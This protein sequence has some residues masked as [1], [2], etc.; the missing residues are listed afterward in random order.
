MA[1]QR[2][3]QG[4]PPPPAVQ[5]VVLRYA[6]RGPLRY[7][8][9]RDLAR[10]F[11]R[12]LRRARVPMAYSAGFHPHPKLSYL[13]AA[14]TGAASEAEYLEVRLARRVE[15][16]ELAAGLTAVLPRD[17][18]I[19]GAVDTTGSTAGGSAAGLDFGAL[20]QASMW[21]LEWD[22]APAPGGVDPAHLERALDTLM[23]APAWRVR[24]PPRPKDKDPLGREL[25]IRPALTGAALCDCHGDGPARVGC[26]IV[27]RHGVPAVRPDDVVRALLAGLPDAAP[28]PL[29]TLRLAQGVLRE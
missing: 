19:L 25:D 7:A 8:S 15:A 4:P 20:L 27:L 17:F 22:A 12:A 29:L 21:R 16:A 10:S 3:P 5:R 26:D 23:A 11:E 14:P 9:A 6:K 13:S 1:K 2:Q 28:T 18:P 24:R